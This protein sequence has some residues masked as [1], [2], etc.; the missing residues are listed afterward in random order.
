VKDS[1]VVSFEEC[2]THAAAGEMAE[3]LRR[4]AVDSTDLRL[5]LEQIDRLATEGLMKVPGRDWGM[6]GQ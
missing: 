5:A 2:R 6:R 3:L 4:I 1:S